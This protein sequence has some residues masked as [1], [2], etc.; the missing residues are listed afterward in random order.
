V[1]LTDA[2]KFTEDVSPICLPKG[3]L[4]FESFDGRKG[5]A[6]GWGRVESKTKAPRQLYRVRL[7]FLDE[8]SCARHYKRFFVPKIMVCTDSTTE[9]AICYGDSGG[10]LCYKR[11]DKVYQV[12]KY[13]IYFLKYFIS[14]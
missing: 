13:L 4:R 12:R 11:Q 1:K 14:I 3:K 9:A 2:V 10:P 8:K 6:V 7:P 5:V